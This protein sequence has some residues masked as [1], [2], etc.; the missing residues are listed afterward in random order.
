VTIGAV[1]NQTNWVDS[2]NNCCAMSMTRFLR[3]GEDGANSPRI[4]VSH[5]M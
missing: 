4:K 2:Y 3:S 5:G 1:G